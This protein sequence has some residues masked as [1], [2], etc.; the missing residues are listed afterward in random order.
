MSFCE[1]ENKFRDNER[2]RLSIYEFIYTLFT[3]HQYVKI[4]FLFKHPSWS[5]WLLLS[6][7]VSLFC[8][9]TLLHF[10]ITF[11]F[12]FPYF[13][14]P[15]WVNLQY[16]FLYTASFSFAIFFLLPF[17]NSI[18]HI[19]SFFFHFAIFP[20]PLAKPPFLLILTYH[21]PL[22]PWKTF[23]VSPSQQL[24]PGFFLFICLPRKRIK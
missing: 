14:S 11:S 4:Q 5:F 6:G 19:T 23:R 2:C 7:C 16:F 12:S 17:S 24:V 21:L 22:V 1:F 20:I 13:P 15:L 3:F 18:C 10:T 9:R 8:W